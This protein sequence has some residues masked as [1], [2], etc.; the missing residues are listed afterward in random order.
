[1]APLILNMST[2]WR[3]AVSFPPLPIYPQGR[4]SGAHSTGGWVDFRE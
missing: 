2:R 4:A 3:W 1:M